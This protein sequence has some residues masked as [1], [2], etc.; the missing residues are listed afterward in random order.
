MRVWGS[1]PKRNHAQWRPDLR[2]FTSPLTQA[3]LHLQLHEKMCSLYSYIVKH[4]KT[5]FRL[6]FIPCSKLFGGNKMQGLW[7]K[8]ISIHSRH[9][10]LW[11]LT[12]IA[13]FIAPHALHTYGF[14]VGRATI[15]EAQPSIPS[16]PEPV[17]LP[18]KP[19]R[20]LHKFPP[21]PEAALRNGEEG[22]VLVRLTIAADGR[23]N[24][25][26][27]AQSSGNGDLDRNTVRW[28]KSRWRY[29]PATLNGQPVV[30]TIEVRVTFAMSR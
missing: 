12:G 25:A 21:Y 17:L 4:S 2:A 1:T 20:H 10:V 3:H 5:E 30:S 8:F 6:V 9:R 26:I 15:T 22:S 18:A 27:I 29:S 11:C 24:D 14:A 16:V 28:I 13:F 7:H 19:I 23:V